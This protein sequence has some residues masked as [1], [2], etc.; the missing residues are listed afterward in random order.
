MIAK[1]DRSQ[2]IYVSSSVTDRVVY[3]TRAGDTC[4]GDFL[5]LAHRKFDI[6]VVCAFCYGAFYQRVVLFLMRSVLRIEQSEV[7]RL[8]RHLFRYKV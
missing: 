5:D 4:A 3:G 6:L 1:R 7:P 2:C 8:T